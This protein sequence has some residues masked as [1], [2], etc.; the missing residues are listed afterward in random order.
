MHASRGK[1]RSG[2]R[3]TH[4]LRANG[5]R[6][7]ASFAQVTATLPREASISPPGRL[8]DARF[9]WQGPIGEAL[10][11]LLASKWGKNVRILRTGNGDLATRSEHLTTRKVERCTLRVARSDR[12]GA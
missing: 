12:G 10:D 11:A 1:V 9:A 7:S 8:R 3:L 2:R 4:C 5:A 6:T